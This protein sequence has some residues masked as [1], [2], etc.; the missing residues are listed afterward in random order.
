MFKLPKLK[1]DPKKLEP[2]M[3]EYIVDLHYNKHHNA[4]VT[5]LNDCLVKYPDFY[6]MDILEIL[7][8]SHMIPVE[9]KQAVIN[10]GGGHYNHTFFWSLITDKQTKPSVKLIKLLNKSFGSL[11]QFIDAFNK[12][13]LQ[14]FGSG[15]CWLVYDTVINKLLIKTT[16]NQN[17]ITDNNLIPILTID[18][19]EHAYYVRYQNDRSAYLNEIWNIINWEEVDRKLNRNFSN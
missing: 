11:E 16:T 5:K 3:N 7:K 2:Y 12:T 10:N 15:W 14:L 4:Y 18:V 17:I 1:F 19:W 13:A 8:N 6:E 9:I